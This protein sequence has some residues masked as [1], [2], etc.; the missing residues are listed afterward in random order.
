MK[1]LTEMMPD[2][3]TLARAVAPMVGQGSSEAVTIGKTVI[4]LIDAL[5]DDASEEEAKNLPLAAL[6]KQRDEIEVRVKM[7]ADRVVGTLSG[8]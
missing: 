8:S 1:T 5:T 2:L 6:K 3:T 4:S 7:H